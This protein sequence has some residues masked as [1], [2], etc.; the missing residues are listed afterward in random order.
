MTIK[1]SDISLNLS[2]G[3]N[4]SNPNLSL[5]G[6]PSIYPVGTNLA[7]LFSNIT[8]LDALTGYQ[9]YR[10]FYVFNNNDTY[11]LYDI[12]I[13]FD[14]ELDYPLQLSL[15]LYLA[16]DLQKL[17]ISGNV[18]SGYIVV[19]YGDTSYSY[20]GNVNWGTGYQD[21][22]TNLENALNSTGGLTGVVVT[23]VQTGATNIFN[24][25]FQ[26][27]DANKYQPT[28]FV[29]TSTLVTAS[30]SIPTINVAKIINGSPINTI[31]DAI[32][33]STTAPNAVVFYNTSATNKKLVG[34]LAPYDGLPVWVKRTVPVNA[35]PSSVSG[36]TFK[37]KGGA[38]I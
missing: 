6:D 25:A 36:A 11:S 21:F 14:T 37:L 22:R 28:L 8:P 23:V 31:P 32:T 12:N 15:G 20:T 24:I 10:C 29:V 38:F 33:D 2:G 9:D 19:R 3:T 27:Y 4:N 16:S 5:G 13:Y 17:T 35:D 1:A 26:G 7:N 34:T 30:A 18:Q